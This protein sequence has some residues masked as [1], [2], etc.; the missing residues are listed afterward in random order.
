M[1]L[2]ARCHT[3]RFPFRRMLA[4][5]VCLCL[6]A[7]APVQAEADVTG[8]RFSLQAQLEPSA[9]SAASDTLKTLSGLSQLLDAMTLEGTLDRSF[10]GSFD[11]NAALTLYG[12]PET[13]TELRVFGT[14]SHWCVQS[15]LLGDETLMINLLA[16]LEFSIKAYSH[17][18]IPLQRA[19]LLATP[20]VHTSAFEALASAWNQVIGAKT[21]SRTISRA[22]VLSLARQMAEIASDDRAFRYWVQAVALESGYDEVMMEVIQALPEWAGEVIGSKGLVITVKGSTETWRTGNTTLFT[23]TIENGLDVWSLTLPPL[24]GGYSLSASGQSRNASQSFSLS[25]T[26]ES[27]GTVLNATLQAASLPETLPV[28]EPFSVDISLAGEAAGDGTH[29][30]LEG[31]GAQGQVTLSLR[32]FDVE[33]P[34]VTISGQLLPYE[35]ASVPSYTAADMTGVNL[36]SI[37]DTTLAELMQHILEPLVRGALPLLVHAPATGVQSLMDLL[38]DSGILALLTEGNADGSEDGGL[39][40]LEE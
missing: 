22:K 21:G 12:L 32:Q 11:L 31:D 20:Y 27:G 35:P 8:V 6:L 34:M 40:V 30:V 25:I 1:N 23:R 18:G 26:E 17:L 33:L 16:L 19:A 2:K 29:L 15:N 10:T 38:A 13:R 24:P 5:L 28:S 39:V 37:N 7:P 4:L 14:D 9:F 3:M 36:L